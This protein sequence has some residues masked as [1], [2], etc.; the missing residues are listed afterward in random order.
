MLRC[1]FQGDAAV[2]IK[3]GAVPGEDRG[4]AAG[5]SVGTADVGCSREKE[6]LRDK[7]KVSGL[8]IHQLCLLG[9][10]GSGV[11]VGAAG[12][13]QSNGTGTGQGHPGPF[14]CYRTPGMT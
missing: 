11:W 5:L 3:A 6:Q 7:G 2:W 10:G 14:C 12:L 9:G 13:T 1:E 4:L 8:T